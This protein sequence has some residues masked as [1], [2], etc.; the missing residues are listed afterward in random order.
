MARKKQLIIPIFAPFGGCDK[1]CVFCDQKKISGASSFPTSAQIEADIEKYLST[2]RGGGLKEAAFYGG[3]FTA[4]P[5]VEQRRMLSAAH[6]FVASGRLDSIR[7]ST[8]PDSIDSAVLKLLIGYGVK[9]IELGV[10]SF[11]DEVLKLSGRPHS[12][13]DVKRA[14]VLIK[15]NGLRLGLQLMPGLPGDTE[16]KA[17]ASAEEAA[18][19]KPDF[20]RIYPTLVIKGTELERMYNSGAYEPWTL[21]RMAMLCSKMLGVF[22]GFGIKVIR[23]GLQPTVELEKNIAAGPYHPAFRDMVERALAR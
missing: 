2:W 20:V 22:G 1:R 3:S 11:D 6:S 19:L 14:A 4:I 23:V 8:R 12:A 16:E 17:T 13:A 10:Q 5:E 18:A 21:D 9:T 7:V 15:E